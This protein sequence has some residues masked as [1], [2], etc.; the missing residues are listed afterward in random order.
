MGQMAHLARLTGSAELGA[1]STSL[2]RASP[3]EG[4]SGSSQG[5][6]I[7]RTALSV[8]RI[9]ERAQSV[10]HGDQ[11]GTMTSHK[12]LLATLRRCGSVAAGRGPT[13]RGESQR[14]PVSLRRRLTQRSRRLAS[15]QL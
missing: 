10:D 13:T 15:A 4:R 5:S 8:E 14:P 12:A 1:Y 2:Q 6:E 7:T 9:S 11:Q 3:S